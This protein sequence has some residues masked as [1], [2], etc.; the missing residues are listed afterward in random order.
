MSVDP[1]VSS[2][3]DLRSAYAAIL[4]P[5][6]IEEKMLRLIRQGRISKWFSGYGQEAIA[7]GVALALDERDYILPTHRNLGVWTTRNVELR[8]LFCQLMGRD[9]GFTKGRDR[10]FHF[11]LPDRRIIGMISHMAAMLPVACG[12]GV[13]S[14]YRDEAIVAAAFVGDGASREGDFHEA[15]NLAAC[16][17]LPVIFVLENNGYGLSTPTSDVVATDDLAAAAVGYGMHGESVDGNDIVAVINAVSS[18]ASRARLEHRPT[19]LEMKTFRMR[20]HEEASGTGYVPDELIE[21]WKALDPVH[22]LERHV[23][24]AG[25][26]T[27]DDAAALRAELETE[28][29]EA[30]E[31]ALAQPLVTSDAETERSDVFAASAPAIRPSSTSTTERR[32]I[33]AVSDGLS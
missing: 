24:D 12:L 30:V 17:S 9:G 20:G 22:R 10:T 18:A 1:T 8:P 2:T 19:L 23:L 11:G 29:N 27:D 5:R 31:F 6:V 15:L 25:I 14:R 32:F 13:A 26:V 4:K 33:D 7:V 3:T 28:V 21:R 16:W